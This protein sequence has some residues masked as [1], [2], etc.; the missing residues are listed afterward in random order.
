MNYKYFILLRGIIADRSSAFVTEEL[1]VRGFLFVIVCFQTEVFYSQIAMLDVCLTRW[2]LMQ[3]HSD[4]SVNTRAIG[5]RTTVM[6]P[7]SVA[8]LGSLNFFV[9]VFVF[10]CNVKGFWAAHKQSCAGLKPLNMVASMFLLSFL[11]LLVSLLFK[12]LWA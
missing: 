6:N 7:G 3:T 9:F 10:F 12:Q 4:L 2:T 8:K 11:L 1:I 5:W